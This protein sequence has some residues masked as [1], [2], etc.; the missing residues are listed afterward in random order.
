M[1]PKRETPS[2]LF[3]VVATASLVLPA[4]VLPIWGQRGSQGVPL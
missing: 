3:L 2:F 1:T 4:S